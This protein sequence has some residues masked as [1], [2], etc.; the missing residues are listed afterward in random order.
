LGNL[1]FFETP[2]TGVTPPPPKKFEREN[3]KTKQKKAARGKRAQVVLFAT[4][5]VVGPATKI[6]EFGTPPKRGE[7][8]NCKK[9]GGGGGQSKTPERLKTNQARTGKGGFGAKRPT[10]QKKKTVGPRGKKQKKGPWGVKTPQNFFFCC[11]VWGFFLGCC[12]FVFFWGVFRPPTPFVFGFLGE[13]K[14]RKQTNNFAV[15]R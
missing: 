12:F 11:F 7:K 4:R 6:G 15:Q 3:L 10:H 9:V 8:K 5:V 1:E 2:Q 13:K 14:P